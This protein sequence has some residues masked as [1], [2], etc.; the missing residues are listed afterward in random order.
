MIKV[1][2][3]IL[4]KQ[5]KLKEQTKQKIIEANLYMPSIKTIN[6]ILLYSKNLE[7]KGSVYVDWVEITKS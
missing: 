1:Y 3:I 4:E 2:P 6:T 5:S 7:L